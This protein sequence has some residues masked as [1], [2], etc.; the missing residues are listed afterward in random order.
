MISQLHLPADSGE[1]EPLLDVEEEKVKD[2]K[3]FT[4]DGN[5]T[6]SAEGGEQAIMDDILAKLDGDFDDVEVLVEAAKKLSFFKDY[7]ENIQAE[8]ADEEEGWQF[9]DCAN[10]DPEE[11]LRD[12]CRFGSLWLLNIKPPTPTVRPEAS[13]T[14]VSKSPTTKVTDVRH[15]TEQEHVEAAQT[16]QH[17]AI[18][19]QETPLKLLQ[20]ADRPWHTIG[21]E[22]EINAKE[23]NVEAEN[24][25]NA[26]KP[27]FEAEN[28]NNAKEPNVEVDNENNA[29][30]PNVEPENEN[31]AKE[32]NVEAENE[33]N[34]KEPKELQQQEI[35]DPTVTGK[36]Q[37]DSR[38]CLSAEAT[39]TV[40]VS[41]WLPSS[42]VAADKK[43]TVSADA[44]AKEKAKAKMIK[45][46]E[47][48]DKS[49]KKVKKDKVKEDTKKK[50]DKDS[51][52]KP[53]KTDNSDVKG[54]A[55][56]SPKI[57]GK[58]ARGKQQASP[59][60]K[61]KAGAQKI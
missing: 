59:N 39:A 1:E 41:Q 16:L 17:A 26:K 23:S 30:E 31:N 40:P 5:G 13:G 2:M 43:R 10:G 29:K 35:Q 32:P 36:G 33:I 34:S 21:T 42:S 58:R 28:E 7:C 8:L 25:T 27:I 15:D 57:C 50:K 55:S 44:T 11:D 38:E 18:Q 46:P 52:G 45:E 54:A 19:T 6:M 37:A 24:E 12:L 61:R 56:T 20:L 60:S 49:E 14:A 4:F 9:G 22:H 48:K 51:H 47:P 3:D 53:K